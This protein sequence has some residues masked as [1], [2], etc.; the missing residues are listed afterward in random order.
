MD[1]VVFDVEFGLWEFLGQ[2]LGRR[3]VQDLVE[4]LFVGRHGRVCVCCVCV[5]CV[6]VCVRCSVVGSVV[7]GV[8]LLVQ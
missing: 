3:R 2:R 4:V 5:L 7:Y 6:T 1:E 8:V